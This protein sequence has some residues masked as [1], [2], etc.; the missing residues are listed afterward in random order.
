MFRMLFE[1]YKDCAKNLKDKI[2]IIFYF[3]I[4][5]LAVIGGVYMLFYEHYIGYKIFGFC[6]VIYFT[7]LE[8]YVWGESF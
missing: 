7:F 2:I 1:F 8:G 6:I 5:I 3:L 4:C